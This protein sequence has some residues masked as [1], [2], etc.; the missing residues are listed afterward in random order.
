MS[1]P[2]PARSPEQSLEPAPA[3]TP[4]SPQ[5]LALQPKKPAN[6]D[7]PRTEVEA[8][9]GANTESNFFVGFSGEVSEGGVF[10]ATYDVLERGSPVDLLVTLPGGYEFRVD[11]WVRFVRDPFDFD[12]GA[13]PG[14]GIQFE[15]LAR[16]S[17]ELVLRFIRKRAP[18]FYDE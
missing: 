16:E 12:E 9:I 1:P 13:H 15:S 2:T 7:G 4:V 18:T 17:R 10:L 5:P 8:N 6:L 14:M 3:Y 11:G